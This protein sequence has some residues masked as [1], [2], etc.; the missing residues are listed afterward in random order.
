VLAALVGHDAVRRQLENQLPPVTLLFGPSSTGK[1]FLAQHTA[2][3]H[4]IGAAD[5]YTGWELTV[6]SARAAAGLAALAPFGPYRAILLDLDESSDDAQ[7]ALLKQLEEPSPVVRY[8]LVASRGPLATVTS[9]CRVYRC[10]YL[11]DAE[12]AMVLRQLGVP[13]AETGKY[14]LLGRGQVGPAYAAATAAKD[15]SRVRSRVSTAIKAAM[16]GGSATFAA[17]V[18]GWDDEHTML[19]RVWAHEAATGRWA[20]FDPS[21]APGAS[22]AQAR[23]ALEYMCRYPG[24]SLSGV[25]AL[26]RAFPAYS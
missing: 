1:R 13:Y 26:R 11:T 16:S 21:Y 6:A 3:H 12:V 5:T 7:H 4:G 17:A 15:G 24:T 8:I 18:M 10:G 23:R 20:F 25:V 2:A 14:A 19:L 9:R 22:A